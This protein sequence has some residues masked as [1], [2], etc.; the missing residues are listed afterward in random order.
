MYAEFSATECLECNGLGQYSDDDGAAVCS[1]APGGYKPNAHRT[2]VTPCPPGRFSIGGATDCSTCVAG[3]FAS[4]EGAVGCTKASTCGAGRYIKTPSSPTADTECEDC[5]IGKASIG[6]QNSC[7]DCD[8]EGEY[9]DA[10]AMSSC[11]N[12]VAG[13]YPV[14]NRQ[15]FELC[16]V[17]KFSPGGNNVS[18]AEYAS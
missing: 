11:K 6:N 10:S 5:A 16:P 17:G 13:T 7:D 12:A 14:L 3:E 8:G 2:G 9:A 18:K 15:D 4:S 1:N